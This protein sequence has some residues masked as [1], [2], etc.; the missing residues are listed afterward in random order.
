MKKPVVLVSPFPRTMGEIFDPRDLD[1]L[2]RF[3]EIAWGRDDVM[4][5]AYLDELLPDLWAYVGFDPPLSEGRLNRA[6]AL[7]SILEVGGHFPPSI[8][9]STCFSRGI[10]VLSCAP[11][12][13]PQVAEMALAMTLGACRGVVGAHLD[14]ANGREE[15]QGD[16]PTDFTLFGQTVGFVGFGAI[17]RNLLPL[18][19]PFRCQVKVYDPWLP[20]SL[21]SQAGCSPVELDALL[22]TSRVVYVLAAPAPENR[23]LLGTAQIALMQPGALL[24]LISRSHLVDFAALTEALR[25]GRI[26]AAI[27][28][29]PE[30][31][32]PLDVAI[33]R[34]PNVILSAHRGASIRKERR[35]IGRMVVDDL[36]LM[37]SGLAP[38]L[39]QPAQPEIIRR[40]IGSEDAIT[41][42]GHRHE[43]MAA[44]IATINAI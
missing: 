33:R 26:Q 34:T 35:S 11:T 25:A 37:A 2:A 12:F 16:R 27:D 39:M 13:G 30:E 9:Y 15:W 4:P 41:R 23:G 5:P 1:R 44:S 40:V 8:D 32:L 3:A 42:T 18:L 29:F 24:V 43:L 21:I 7:R 38:V 14:F 6:E 36:E 19:A 28:V 17:A 10:R 22:G 20:A 31:P